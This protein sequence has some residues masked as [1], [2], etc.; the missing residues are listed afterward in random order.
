MKGRLRSALARAT[1][2]VCSLAATAL[3]LEAGLRRFPILWPHGTYDV[4]RFSADLGLMV[5]GAPAIYNRVRWNRRAV[6][7]DGFLDVE[8]GRQKPA[9][10]RRVGFFGDSYVEALQVPL[11]DTFFRR[12]QTQISGQQ[13]E[14]LAFGISG[15][16]TLHSL[17]AYRVMAPRYDLDDV[18]YVFVTNDPGDNHSKVK[19]WADVSA[20]ID[21][22]GPGFL[23]RNRREDST[24]DRVCRSYGAESMVA[25]SV[26]GWWKMRS[27]AQRDEANRAQPGSVDQNDRRTHWPP[28]LLA[29]TEIL[30]RRILQQ[31]RDEVARDG[32]GFA[33]L[34]VPRGNEEL[35]GT[36][37]PADSWVPWLSRTCAE[38]GIPLWNPTAL[39]RRE[40][41][42]GKVIYDDHWSPAGHERIASFVA[43]QLRRT[44]ADPRP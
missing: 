23:I 33:V 8:H 43:E 34:Y 22:D 36:L 25:R 24:I 12:L 4:P 28:E 21:P 31:F 41:A 10:V 17:M 1:L 2:V 30:A 44:R 3:L 6:N 5:H 7:R 32:R 18:V 35:E 19:R 40:H 14:V 27:A 26:C 11:E 20:E 42:A 15:W 16:G 39:L 29:E 37:E 38:L 13:M 9:G